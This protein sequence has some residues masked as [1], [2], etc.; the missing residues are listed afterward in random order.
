MRPAYVHNE[1][2]EG[3]A[4]VGSQEASVPARSASMPRQRAGR[5]VS[6]PPDLLVQ[7]SRDPMPGIS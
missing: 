4:R 1:M 7:N 6:G 2:I 5:K 3:Q